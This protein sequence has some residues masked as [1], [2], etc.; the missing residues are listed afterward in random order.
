MSGGVDRVRDWCD[1]ADLA[2]RED[3]G[4]L[5][6]RL[7]ADDATEVRLELDGDDHPLRIHDVVPLT[8]G[9]LPAVR[10]AEV[11]EEVVLSRSS[12]IDARLGADGEAAEVVLMIHAE[13]LNRHTFLEAVFEIQKVRLL[14]HREVSAAVA[15]EQTVATLTAMA[16]RAWAGAPASV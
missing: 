8:P 3:D 9:A 10:V 6:V 16:D 15:A 13:G 2:W 12:L 14:L 5:F 11:V 1:T 4:E 7:D